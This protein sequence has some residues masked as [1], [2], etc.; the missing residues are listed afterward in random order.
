MAVFTFINGVGGELALFDWTFNQL[1]ISIIDEQFF[2]GYFGNVA[3]FKKN[4]AL[5]DWQ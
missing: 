5:G 1:V 4:K 3:F 2:N